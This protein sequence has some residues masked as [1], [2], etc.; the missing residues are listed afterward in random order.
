MT[1]KLF[2]NEDAL[3]PTVAA[4]SHVLAGYGLGLAAL[5]ADRRGSMPWVCCCSRM[6]W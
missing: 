6:R 3:I 4:F 2:R 1:A 5:L